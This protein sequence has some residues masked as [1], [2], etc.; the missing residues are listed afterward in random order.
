MGWHEMCVC[1]ALTA[2]VFPSYADSE[3]NDV[4]ARLLVE[5]VTLCI[6]VAW[7]CDPQSSADA[8]T[9]A[10]TKKG[11]PRPHAALVDMPLSERSRMALQLGYAIT[12]TIIRHCFDVQGAPRW[13]GAVCVFTEWLHHSPRFSSAVVRPA[14]PALFVLCVRLVN[15]GPWQTMTDRFNQWRFSVYARYPEHC[16]LTV[17]RGC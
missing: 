14:P 9:A 6:F 12:G 3:E 15:S 1:M 4:L 17:C 10:T 8:T 2:G 13:L 5:A 11:S 16:L 7:S